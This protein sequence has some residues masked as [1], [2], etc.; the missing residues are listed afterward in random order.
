MKLG[1]RGSD[2]HHLET[3]RLKAMSLFRNP[4]TPGLRT[5]GDAVISLRPH[6]RWEFTA[7]AHS[8]LFPL[9][10][11][12]NVPGKVFDNNAQIQGG[13]RGRG[14]GKTCAPGR[15]DPG[16]GR[17]TNRGPGKAAGPRNQRRGGRVCGAPADPTD[18]AA[19]AAAA[20]GARGR[21]WDGG[22]ALSAAGA[23]HAAG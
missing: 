7:Q 10:P 13:P 23:H 2:C 5:L 14:S 12:V 20:G 17:R 4:G 8:G 9:F 15:A 6:G 21:A 11:R 1:K 16:W 22:P 19:S 18:F 3:A